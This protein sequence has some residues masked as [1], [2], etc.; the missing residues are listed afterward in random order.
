MLRGGLTL[1]F[2]C[3]FGAWI[4]KSWKMDRP[5]EPEAGAAA[6][7][8]RKC[9]CY[10]GASKGWICLLLP[11]LAHTQLSRWLLLSAFSG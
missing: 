7:A 11:T 5:G 3:S 9:D 4:G 10:A 6:K 8:E 1:S 2:A